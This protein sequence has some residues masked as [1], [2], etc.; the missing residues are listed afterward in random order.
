M[1]PVGE[2]EVA[3]MAA[4]EPYTT[5]RELTMVAMRDWVNEASGGAPAVH[6]Q[7]V[8]PGGG[9]FGAAAHKAAV[10]LE[11]GAGLP[12]MWQALADAGLCQRPQGPFVVLREGAPTAVA[13]TRSRTRVGGAARTAILA[14]AMR[15]HQ[16]R[17]R[18]AQI[19]AALSG[20]E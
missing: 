19:E 3:E 20:L 13:S 6:H 17:R 12:A 5:A 16:A 2:K 7:V 4:K 8:V 14:T 15:R 10:S 9:G 11:A 18:L 1:S